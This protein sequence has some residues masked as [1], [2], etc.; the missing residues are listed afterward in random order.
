M[1]ADKNSSRRRLKLQ[2]DELAWS[3]PKNTRSALLPFV[4]QNHIATGV[5]LVLG[6]TLPAASTPTRTR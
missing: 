2:Q 1:G 4:C 3:D 6:T 5:L